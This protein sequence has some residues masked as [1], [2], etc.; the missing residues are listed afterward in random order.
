[1]SRKPNVWLDQ[2]AVPDVFPHSV[3]QAIKFADPFAC[4][5][6]S[7][8]LEFR[9]ERAMIYCPLKSQHGRVAILG[10]FLAVILQ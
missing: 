1:M 8:G 5:Y 9:M 4:V 10:F 2:S 6:F 7:I 3:P